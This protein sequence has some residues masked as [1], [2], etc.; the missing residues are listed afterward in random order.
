MKAPEFW[1]KPPGAAA[2]LLSPAG[3][4]FAAA[5][6]LRMASAQP[7]R[8]RVP[9]ICIGNLVAGGAGKTP[10]ALAVAQA[11]GTRQVHFLTRGYGGREAGPLRVDPTRHDATDVGDEALLLAGARPTWVARDRVAGGRAAQDAGAEVII[12]DDGFQNPALA[13]DLSL[14]VVDGGA[15]FGNRHVIPA[16]PLREPIEAGLDRADAVVVLGQDRC[17]TADLIGSRRPILHARLVPAP[18]AAEALRGQRVVAFAGIGRPAKFFATVEELGADLIERIAFADHHPYVPD[19][20]MRMVEFAAASGAKL[21]TT[22]KDA[23]RLPEQARGMVEVV[24]V[25]VVWDDPAALD[26]VLAPCLTE[27]AGHGR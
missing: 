19:E 15:G 16:G 3:W 25:S 7:E 8:L 13:K 1:Y 6:R 5:G 4:L 21:V 10:V 9:V 11:L 22:A 18:G 20:I 12:M 27:A 24:P 17:G 23:V 2:V 14:L 26:R